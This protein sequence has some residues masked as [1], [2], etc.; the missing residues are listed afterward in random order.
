MAEIMQNEISAASL[1]FIQKRR[2]PPTLIGAPNATAV[3]QKIID[4]MPENCELDGLGGSYDVVTLNLRSNMR[5]TDAHFKT[6]AGSLD[7]ASPITINGGS[8]SKSKIELRGIHIDGNRSKQTSIDSQQKGEDGGRHGFRILG[9]VSEL[10]MQ[11]CSAVN[12][13]ADGLELYRFRTT[14]LDSVQAFHKIVIENFSAS[15]NRRHGISIDSVDGV[16]FISPYLVGNGLD[17]N[18]SDV[19]S[20]GTRGARHLGKLY[21][22]GIDAEGYGLGSRITDFS[23][24]NATAIGNAAAGILFFDK[25]AANQAGFLPRSNIR[26]IGGVT[27]AGVSGVAEGRGLHIT[28]TNAKKSFGAIYRDVNIDSMRVVGGFLFRSVDNLT[29]KGGAVF[30]DSPNGYALLDY[31]TNVQID[32]LAGGSARNYKA[33]NSTFRR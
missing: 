28:S 13:A 32:T 6:I 11:D 29:V 20:T 21:G 22:N 19:Q 10:L 23:I 7:M 27:D 4:A 14:A 25:V 33:Y 24:Q 8:F 12:C 18:T 17:I 1:N 31:A 5:M 3:I 15:G 16:Q 2:L 30:S 9:R 26:L